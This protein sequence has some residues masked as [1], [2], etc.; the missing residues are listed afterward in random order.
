MIDIEKA[1]QEF[2]KYVNELNLDN[3]KV[4]TK[5]D[6]TFRVSNICKKIASNLNLSNEQIP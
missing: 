1:K 5:L 6:H 3:P 2:I 4:Q